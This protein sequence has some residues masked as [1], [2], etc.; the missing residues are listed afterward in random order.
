MSIATFH[1]LSSCELELVPDAGL[2]LAGS[3][4]TAQADQSGHGRNATVANAIADGFTLAT[5]PTYNATDPAFGNKPSI[6]YANNCL[7]TVNVGAD[8]T[9]PWTAIFAG[10]GTMAAGD[11]RVA[12][13][14]LTGLSVAYSS[15]GPF[16]TR[17]FGPMDMNATQ[18]NFVAPADPQEIRRIVGCNLRAPFVVAIA[19]RAPTFGTVVH[20]G[21]VRACRTMLAPAAGAQ[22]I[23]GVR[24]GNSSFATGSATGSWLGNLPLFVLYS[25]EL[26]WSELKDATTLAG[27]KCGISWPTGRAAA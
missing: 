23:R 15:F 19:V 10:C 25:R 24:V 21:R 6:T 1:D 11:S 12:W 5:G 9:P 16:Y 3:V 2:T 17:N 26:G 4:L 14:T 27:A 7:A 18:W 22:L 20:N 13:D 8:I